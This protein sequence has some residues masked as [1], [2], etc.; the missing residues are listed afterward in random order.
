[1]E[2]PEQREGGREWGWSKSKYPENRALAHAEFSRI[3]VKQGGEEKSARPGSAA[4]PAR[5]R[6]SITRTR[7]FY[8]YTHI[9]K[10]PPRVNERRDAGEGGGRGGLLPPPPAH[11]AALLF[12]FT[13]PSALGL[14]PSRV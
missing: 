12:Q 10:E 14:H 3:K 4:A 1:M 8:V 11:Y 7:A 6:V 13:A 5:S 9:G 2:I